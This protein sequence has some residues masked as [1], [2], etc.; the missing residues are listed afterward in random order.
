MPA[1]FRGGGAL[2]APTPSLAWERNSPGLLGLT[3]NQ[4]GGG[5]FDHPLDVSRRSSETRNGLA[6]QFHEFFLSSI[7][8]LLRPNL[9]RPRIPFLGHASLKKF[10]NPKMAQKRDFVYKV[11][12]KLSFIN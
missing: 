11:N 7:A 4:L 8:Q 1:K 5:Q 6:A 2:C 10:V 12:A 9:S 3:L